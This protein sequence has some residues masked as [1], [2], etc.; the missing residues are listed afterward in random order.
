MATNDIDV[1]IVSIEGALWSGQ[2]S[3]VVAT[4][5]SGEIGIL[6]GRQ[7]LLAELA[8][9]GIVIVRSETSGPQVFAVAGGLLSCTGHT[10][11]VIAHHAIAV[12]DID[13]AALSQKTAQAKASEQ[14]EEAL[15]FLSAQQ[16]AVERARSLT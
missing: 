16:Q 15:A 12:A 10:V 4:I 6:P 13:E 2:A 1:A 3:S 5:V 9:A 11:K 8:E 7:P 14:D